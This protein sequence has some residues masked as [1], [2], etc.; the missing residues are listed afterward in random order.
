M[1]PALV[2]LAGFFVAAV[3]INA[4][5]YGGI[6]L[7]HRAEQRRGD[8]PSA[9]APTLQLAEAGPDD[10]EPRQLQKAA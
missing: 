9:K 2:A 10:R 1:D 3:V 7:V 4:L 6:V 5:T 8:A